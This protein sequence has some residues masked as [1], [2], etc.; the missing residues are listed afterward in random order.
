MTLSL[1]LKFDNWVYN[2][3]AEPFELSEISFRPGSRG[4]VLVYIDA[5]VVAAR[6]NSVVGAENWSDSYSTVLLEDTRDYAL[7]DEGKTVSKPSYDGNYRYDHVTHKYGGIKCDL[8][9]LGLTKSDI[10]APSSADQ[11]KGATSDALKRAAVKFG[12]GAYLYD[13]KGL[14]GAKIERNVVVEP[15]EM[16]DWALPVARSDPKDAILALLEDIRSSDLSDSDKLLGETAVQEVMAMG[17]YDSNAPLIV[18]RAV[19]ER[20]LELLGKRGS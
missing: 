16:P 13:L 7:D 9:I 10:G 8:T 15:P 1:P 20:L 11:L 4:S 18:Q 12:V 3:L 14:K 17:K 5:R 19:Y 2:R 6:L